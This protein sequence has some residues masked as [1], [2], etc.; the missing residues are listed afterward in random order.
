VTRRGL[1]VVLKVRVKPGGSRPQRTRELK[2]LGIA[3]RCALGKGRPCLLGYLD[4]WG[5]GPGHR[6]GDGE[7]L[8]GGDRL[9]KRASR[10][11]L[12]FNGDWTG[13]WRLL[14]PSNGLRRDRLRDG[15]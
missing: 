3:T 15:G 9:V 6:L 8:H 1:L 5:G 2:R 4:L 11:I 13:R 10:D 12:D 14:F 7:L